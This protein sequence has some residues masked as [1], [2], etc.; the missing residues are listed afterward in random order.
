M[1][2][3]TDL[4]HS[5]RAFWCRLGIPLCAS[6][7]QQPAA[8]TDFTSSPVPGHGSPLHPLGRD[9]LLHACREFSTDPCRGAQLAARNIAQH[10]Q[11]KQEVSSC[12]DLSAE[13]MLMSIV[14]LV[15]NSTDK[16]TVGFQPSTISSS[17]ICYL[18]APQDPDLDLQ[19]INPERQA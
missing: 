4:Q 19:E 5:Q 14:P 10:A 1:L 6:S 9:G 16:A 7:F 12:Q 2:T 11:S 13:H 15:L 8:M 17:A 3:L 18:L